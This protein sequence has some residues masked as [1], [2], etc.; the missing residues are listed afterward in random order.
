MNDLDIPR[1]CVVLRNGIEIWMPAEKAEELSMLLLDGNPTRFMKFENTVFNVADVTGIFT[2]SEMQ[3]REMLKGN[4]W[5][6]PQGEW[7]G[8]FDFSD[9]GR[10]C[11]CP[12]TFGN[13]VLSAGSFEEWAESA[14]D[15]QQEK[16]DEIDRSIARLKEQY[17]E[18]KKS[19]EILKNKE[20]EPDLAVEEMVEWVKAHRR[21]YV[22]PDREAQ[23]K[24]MKGAIEGIPESIKIFE[25]RKDTETIWFFSNI[26]DFGLGDPAQTYPMTPQQVLDFRD[27]LKKQVW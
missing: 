13:Q 20:P 16:A 4:F 19:I 26:A 17:A 14:R 11:D 3:E 27:F 18:G 21:M 2:P 9:K 24:S 25:F 8:R 6:C 12:Q 10:K 15:R 22:K 5:K 1:R 7:H 23:I